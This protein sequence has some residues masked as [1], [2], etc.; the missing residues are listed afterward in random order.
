M[1][2][3]EYRP[4]ERLQPFIRCYWTLHATSGCDVAPQRVF[5]DGSME[6]IFHLGEPFQRLH[7]KRPAERQATSLF[8]GQIWTPVDLQPSPCADVVGVRFHPAGAWPF[9]GIPMSELSGRIEPLGG[10]WGRRA[11]CWRERLGEARDRIA[12]L[13]SMLLALAPLDL[14]DFPALSERQHRRR[15]LERVGVPPKLFS[16]IRR[17]QQALAL[18]GTGP[19][20]GVAAQCGYTDQSHLVRDFRQFAGMPPSEW[21]RS[22]QD[23]RFFQDALAAE[24]LD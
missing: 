23:V 21:L 8:A 24:S 7:D 9:F 5:P 18:A 13:E 14:P 6:L 22:R 16:R 15:F 11:T 1:E 2:Y 10:V 12:A 19:L 20:A 17:F 3:R 4:G